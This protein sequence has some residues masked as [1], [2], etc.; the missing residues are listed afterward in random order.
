[1]YSLSGSLTKVSMFFLLTMI[2]CEEALIILF[3]LEPPFE[4]TNFIRRRYC[5]GGSFVDLQLAGKKALVTAA[6]QG[7]GN[8]IANTLA[9][10]GA[11]VSICARTPEK[12]AAAVE[13]LKS[14]GTNVIGAPC[15]VSD[16]DALKAWV[17]DSAAQLGGID[18]LVNNASAGGGGDLWDEHYSID[19]M[20]TVNGTNAA[21]PFLTESGTG[22]V[23]TISTCAAVEAFPPPPATSAGAYGAMKA[24]QLNWSSF[25]AIQHAPNGIRF[26]VVSPGPTYFEGGPSHNIEQAMPPFF[27][28]IKANAPSGFGSGTD[29]A[30]VAVFLASPASNHTTGVNVVVDGG[31][32]RR[33]DF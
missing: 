33:V 26:N 23:V 8:F 1:M 30:N 10:E 18:I 14:H 31:F 9:A 6:S 25:A 16:P 29:V 3:Y 19:M 5:I 2:F 20:A 32:T 17:E 4:G 28:M 12:V 7:I 13:E 15:D 21:L 22:S 24:A 27:E 11:D